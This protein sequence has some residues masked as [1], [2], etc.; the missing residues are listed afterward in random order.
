[1]AP[2][3]LGLE[4]VN[5]LRTRYAYNDQGQVERV[6][7]PAGT[8]TIST[9]DGLARL[10][11][12]YVGTDDSTTNGFKWTPSNAAP[13]SNMVQVAAHEYDN[14]GVGN[15]NL[16]KST[17][18]PGGGA[19]PRVTQNAYDWRNRLVATKSGATSDLATEDPSVNRPLSKPAKDRHNPQKNV[20]PDK[21]RHNP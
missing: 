19:A 5:F 20:K 6:Q 9:Y 11:G 4:G 16:T 14:G 17:Q 18:F 21:D 1:M 3:T 7:N 13:T 12:T 2:A 8:I 15:G 10:T